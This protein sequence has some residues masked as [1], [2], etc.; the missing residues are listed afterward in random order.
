MSNKVIDPIALDKRAKAM[1]ALD[2]IKVMSVIDAKDNYKII[3]EEII[4]WR[5]PENYGET[6]YV[7]RVCSV[8][9]SDRYDR[10]DL[11]ETKSFDKSV[12]ALALTDYLSIYNK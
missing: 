5:K 2:Q 1:N 3:Y 8:N 9:P 6:Y 12:V 11:T 4:N 10:T 7:A